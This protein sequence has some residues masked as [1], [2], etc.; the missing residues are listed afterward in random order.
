MHNPPDV[1]DYSIHKFDGTPRRVFDF[2]NFLKGKFD[3]LGY[4]NLFDIVNNPIIEL[5][6]A[7]LDHA[8]LFVPS[9]NMTTRQIQVLKIQ[10]DTYKSFKINLEKDNEKSFKAIQMVVEHC[11]IHV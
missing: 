9:D 7:I 6:Q 1:W 5:P 10:Q 11:N 2:I 4:S 8:P 3:A